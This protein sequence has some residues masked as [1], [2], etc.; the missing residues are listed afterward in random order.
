MNKETDTPI[1]GNHASTSLKRF[2]IGLPPITGGIVLF[3][4]LL[5]W[6]STVFAQQK[7]GWTTGYWAGWARISPKEIPWKTYT[8]LCIFSATPDGRGGC[9]LAMGWNDSRVKAAITEAHNNNVKVLLC[10]G[11][12]GTGRNFVSSTA[13]AAVRATLITNIISL[14][15]K[16]GFD[17]VDMDWE[18]LQG[19]NA[20]YVALHKE[21]RAELDKITPRPL[22][23]AA[24]A[25]WMFNRTTAQIHPSMDQLNNMS[26]WTRIIKDGA[27]DEAQIAKDMQGLVDK[28]VP[29]AKLGVG[30][31]LDYEERRPEVD[32]DPQACTAKCRFAIANGF[33]GVMIWA[34]DKDAKKFGGKHPC[35]DAVAPF[36]PSDSRSTPGGGKKE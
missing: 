15:R 32:C 22:L 18:E 1:T 31:G 9:N 17:G 27:V 12:A 30:I 33:G 20:E 11:G 34:I 19:K 29:K 8:H 28:G 36:T 10:V 7:V 21:L 14:M 26:Y 13:E 4:V 3:V 5:L 2:P 23:T 6:S 35:H 16:Y 24:I 25:N